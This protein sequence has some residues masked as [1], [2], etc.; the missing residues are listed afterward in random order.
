[1]KWLGVS[2]S[3]K[4]LTE[5]LKTDLDREVGLAL[6]SGKGIVT[7]GSLGT[8]YRAANSACQFA[9]GCERAKIVLPTTLDIYLAHLGNRA[10]QGSVTAEDYSALKGLLQL[11]A[12]SGNIVVQEGFESVSKAAYDSRNTLMLSHTDELVAFQ[13]G[14]SPG[15]RDAVKKAEL[16]DIPVKLFKYIA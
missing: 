6:E 7:G 2:G 12:Y 13:I 14:D 5:A 4:G 1:M 15:T 16:Q 11:V 9:P 10:L 8:D 3:S